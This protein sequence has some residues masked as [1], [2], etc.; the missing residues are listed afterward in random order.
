MSAASEVFAEFINR[1][2]L[3]IIID[4]LDIRN[5][6]S[7]KAQAE[8]FIKEL[9]E[10]QAQQ[11]QQPA[12]ELQVAQDQDNTFREVE[13]AKIEQRHLESEAN[14]AVQSA[15]VSVEKQKA[16]TQ[17]LAIMAEIENKETKQIIEQERM[18]SENAKDAVET[19]LAIAKMGQERQEKRH[20]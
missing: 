14:V 10:R 12:I 2:G 5:V 7:L 4:N 9:E 20:E 15:R 11:A 18:D 8:E 1:K 19:A 13:M 17:F 3:P 16:D 6:D